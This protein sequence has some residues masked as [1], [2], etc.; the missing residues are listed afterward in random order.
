VFFTQYLQGTVMTRHIVATVAAL[1]VFAASWPATSAA[2]ELPVERRFPSSVGEVL[3]KHQ[4]HIQERG[5]GCPECHHQIDAKKLQTPHPQ[6]FKSSWIN[7]EICHVESRKA[8]RKAFTCSE[9]HRTNPV[10]IADETL[11]AKVVIHR[12]CWKCHA[13]SSGKDASKGCA[14]CHAGKKT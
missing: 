3:F 11:S 1:L 2:Q 7:C 10:N 6:Y 8:E 9:C 12:Q 14:F 13:V 5:I 4:L